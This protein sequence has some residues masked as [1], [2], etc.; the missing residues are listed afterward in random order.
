VPGKTFFDAG[1]AGCL[2]KFH[3]RRLAREGGLP[4][5]PAPVCTAAVDVQVPAER[6]IGRRY[7]VQDVFTANAFIHT[8]NIKM[9]GA[10]IPY[11]F[12]LENYFYSG[13]KYRNLPKITGN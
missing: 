10:D 7:T 9:P 12:F 6:Q 11:I 4:G 13:R 5:T 1:T 3:L 8:I 2:E